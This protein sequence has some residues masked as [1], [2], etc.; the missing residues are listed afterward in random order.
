MKAILEFALPEEGSD[1]RLAQNAY[2]YKATLEALSDKIRAL[3]KHSDTK[4]KSWA[5]VR[6]LFN[7][8][9]TDKDCPALHSDD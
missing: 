8:I 7:E 1:F 5:E 4:P 9:L 3:D 2:K 6:N